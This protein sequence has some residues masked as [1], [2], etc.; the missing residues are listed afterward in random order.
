MSHAQQVHS[1]CVA[2]GHR[3]RQLQLDLL[4]RSLEGWLARVA[5]ESRARSLEQQCCRRVQRIQ[6]TGV[7]TAWSTLAA[8]RHRNQRV[9]CKL[10]QRAERA[11]LA[12]AWASW[13][14]KASS[15]RNA[16]IKLT[17]V[18]T[19]AQAGATARVFLSW[20]ER[21]ARRRRSREL[22]HTA[23]AMLQQRALVTWAERTQ[24]VRQRREKYFRLVRRAEVRTS[25]ETMRAWRHHVSQR[26][27]LRRA[28][29]GRL[30]AALDQAGERAS[31]VA[32]GCCL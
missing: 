13:R 5:S 11:C 21:S 31:H 28:V 24:M 9:I 15:T 3:K 14:G 32:A 8:S 25:A 12:A 22:A 23:N 30:R 26:W 18:A 4:S 17:A 27:T 29:H 6:L 1:A 10:R 16:C 2:A 20:R 19:A 7:L